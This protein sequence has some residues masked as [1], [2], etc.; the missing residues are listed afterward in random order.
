MTRLYFLH[1]NFPTAVV[2]VSE[3]T[4]FPGKSLFL[5][6]PLASCA[7]GT[8][9]GGFGPNCIL[10]FT[11]FQASLPAGSNTICIITSPIGVAES[12]SSAIALALFSTTEY[13]ILSGGW[14]FIDIVYS[15][16]DPVLAR[17]RASKDIGFWFCE[18][19]AA[20]SACATVAHATTAKKARGLYIG[21]AP[22][23][24]PV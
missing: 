11:I 3:P 22:C 5:I 10:A 24:E 4:N 16:H 13:F 1:S 23:E 8:S 17:A 20:V 21:S 7:A 15:A 18:L 12:I 6:A 2:T 19:L 9:C 14:P